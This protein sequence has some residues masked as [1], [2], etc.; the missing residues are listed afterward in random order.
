MWVGIHL[1]KHGQLNSGYT[2]GENDTCI[3]TTVN[4]SKFLESPSSIH[5][6]M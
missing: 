5:N 2:T 6:K 4:Y 3:F 1:Q